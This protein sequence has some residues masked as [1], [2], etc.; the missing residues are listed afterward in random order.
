M[1]RLLIVFQGLSSMIN[2]DTVIEDDNWQIELENAE[3]FCGDICNKI[4]DELSKIV[5][6]EY[7]PYNIEISILLSNDSKL[8][9][10]NLEYRKKDKP[11]NVLS[12]PN[13]N[14]KIDGLN[15]L[16]KNEVPIMLGD[17]VFSYQTIKGESDQQNKEF[18][19]HFTHLITH[20]I[21]HLFG[22]NHEIENEA[23]EMESVEIEILDK[24][25]IKN[26]Y[27]GV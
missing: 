23:K 15:R 20:G 22:Y 8:Q 9:E 27:R 13:F 17:I 6:V 11:T 16:K 25:G 26:P 5:N 14:I 7:I 4:L 12:F 24:L 18:K 10:L 1:V 21:L 2:I 19:D 3:Q